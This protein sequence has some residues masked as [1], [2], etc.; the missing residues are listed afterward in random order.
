MRQSIVF[1][2]GRKTEKDEGDYFPLWLRRFVT[3]VFDPLPNAAAWKGSGITIDQITMPNGA[4][5]DAC[6][7]AKTKV[8]TGERATDAFSNVCFDGEGRFHFIGSPAFSMEF[9]D[10]RGFGKKQ[11]PRHYVDNPEPGTTLVGEVIQLDDGSKE[12]KAD[13][14]VALP[15]NDDRFR[16]IPVSSA[17]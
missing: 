16:S 7:K 8:G 14:F 5:S 9:H 13:T 17:Q 11:V 15:A 3:A 2:D 6:A 12:A 1:V 10:Y 4:K